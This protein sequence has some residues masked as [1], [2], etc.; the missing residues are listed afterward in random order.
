MII[1]IKDA[2][3]VFTTLGVVNCLVVL[4]YIHFFRSARLL[5]SDENE[6]CG[7]KT[8]DSARLV[9]LDSAGALPQRPL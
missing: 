7:I 1:I 5:E 2:V 9:G 8:F 6:A 3:L 4:N